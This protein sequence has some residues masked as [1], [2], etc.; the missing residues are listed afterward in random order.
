M[1]PPRQSQQD[2]LQAAK[3][4]LGV[5]WDTLALRSGIKPR[6]LKNYQLP[7]SS[8]GFRVMPDLARAAVEDLIRRAAASPEFDQQ[9]FLR[10]AMA[11]LQL[12]GSQLAEAAG[13]NGSTF[14][15]YM[16]AK[17]GLAHRPLPPLAR[18]AVE[19][20]VRDRH[21]KGRKEGA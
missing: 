21:R 7:E 1:T 14:R 2:F 10:A 19:R 20:L 18:A 11:T 13:I 9:E 17:G 3:A 4:A 16:R 12:T 6:A 5:D 8:K 15:N